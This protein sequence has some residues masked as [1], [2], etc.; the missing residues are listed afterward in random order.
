MEAKGNGQRD[1]EGQEQRD[2]VPEGRCLTPEKGCAPSYICLASST[3]SWNA[4]IRA[5]IE[6]KIG[7][8][9]NTY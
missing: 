9:E 8:E 6:G 5:L 1:E 2:S 4:S 7:S 3:P